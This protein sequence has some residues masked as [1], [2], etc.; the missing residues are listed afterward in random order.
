[1]DIFLDEWDY[2]IHLIR[3]AIHDIQPREMPES[4]SFERVCEFGI[5]HE[6]ANIAFDS[7][8]RL[9]KKPEP[10]LYQKWEDLRNKAIVR[11]I[12]QSWA[13]E[14]IRSALREAG[15]R[16]TEVQGTKIQPLYP[17]PEWRTM[18]DLDFIIDPENLSGVETVLEQLGYTCRLVNGDEVQGYRPPN[19]HIEMHSA[20]FSQYTEY[21]KVMR[22]PFAALDEKGEPVPEELYLYNILHIF[23]HYHYAGF[24]IR[25]V[26][27]AYFLNRHYGGRIQRETVWAALAQAGAAEFA[28]QLASLAENW[29]SET[30]QSISRNEIAVHIFRWGVHGTGTTQRKNYLKQRIP[31]GKWGEKIRYLLER[32]LGTG[33]VIRQN[34]PIVSR[35][36]ILYPVCWLHRLLR[37][38]RPAALKRLGWEIGQVIRMKKTRKEP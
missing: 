21:E 17:K 10:E 3:C 27:D 6:V 32:F 11:H 22:P 18:S 15:I 19:I 29:F 37:G 1:M 24:G 13:A 36:W 25:R 38:L 23:K 9:K 30:E 26:L 8:E 33:G 7:V 5:Y 2:L 4:L 35:F 14:E 34:Y 20:Y 12:N 16:W 31:Q 28:D